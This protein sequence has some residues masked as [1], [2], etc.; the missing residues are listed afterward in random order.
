MNIF[1]DFLDSYEE[2]KDY[3]LGAEFSDVENPA[4]GVKYPLICTD[5]P[6]RCRLEI[7]SNIYNYLHRMPE[8]IT[9]FM[10]R[11]PKGIPVPHIAHHDLSMGSYSLMLYCN[12]YDGG[13]TAMLRHRETGMCYA[14]ESDDFVEI[15][16][17]DQNNMDKWAVI[18]IADMKQNRAVIFDA[19][20]FHCAMP[21]GGFGSG[22]DAR[23]VL[24]VF[25]S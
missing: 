2:L 10:R 16:R 6:E 15:A 5:I 14:P 7:L 19:G 22:N 17:F 8:N 18:D 11:S 4:D 1:D 24:T 20:Y 13:G 23:T 9:M 21:I 12:D 25:F 3:S